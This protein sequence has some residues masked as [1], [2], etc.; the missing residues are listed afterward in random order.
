MLFMGKVD[1]QL[2]DKNRLRIP[3]RFKKGLV[4]ENG[5]KTYSFFRGR[6]NCICVME[7]EE[8]MKLLQPFSDQVIPENSK[9]TRAI[10]ASISNAEEDAQGRVV[11]PVNLR[12]VAGIQKEIVT[13]GVGN[14]LE[15]W[16]AEKY[17]EY[18][19]DVDYDNEWDALLRRA[20]EAKRKDVKEC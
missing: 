9:I 17:Y 5:E 2:D 13:I 1:H 6:N 15:I 19:D 14:R 11:L 3:S 18:M 10:F 20:N 4:G 7:D 8:M 12:K 16:A